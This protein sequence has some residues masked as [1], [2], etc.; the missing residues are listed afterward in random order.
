[1]EKYILRETELKYKSY[2]KVKSIKFTS[3]AMVQKWFKELTNEGREKM[4][5]VFLNSSNEVIAYDYISV[6]TVDQAVVYP[7]EIVRTALLVDCTRIIL[8]HNHP[9]GNPKPS[10]HDIEIT[11]K[12]KQGCETLDIEVLDHIIIA[13]DNFYSFREHGLI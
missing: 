4:I 1:M 5:E 11:K 10:E 8:V 12:I 2:K 9:S 3:P 7:R 6:G 13:N